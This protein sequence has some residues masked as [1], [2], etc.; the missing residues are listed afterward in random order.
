MLILFLLL[1]NGLPNTRSI[2]PKTMFVR[3]AALQQ[4]PPSHFRGL[5]QHSLALGAA[6]LQR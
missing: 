5:Q 1:P 3:T 6:Q 4:T 2:A